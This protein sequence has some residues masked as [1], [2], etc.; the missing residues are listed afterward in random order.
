MTIIEMEPIEGI[1]PGSNNSTA[2]SKF[3]LL[4]EE[5]RKRDLPDAIALQINSFISIAERFPGNDPRFRSRLGKLKNKIIRLLE[6]ELKIVP[7]NYYRTLWMAVGIGAFGMP[8]GVALGASFVNM[9]FI[10]M[11]LLFGIA[12]GLTLETGM[13]KKAFE[14]GRQLDIDLT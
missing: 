6:K 4:I 12:I 2:L 13:D 3:T 14:E 9:G 8:I 1:D 7:R 11:G 5:L 10:G